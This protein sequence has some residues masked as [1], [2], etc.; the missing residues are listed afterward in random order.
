MDKFL[1][2]F[3]SFGW[4]KGI[5]FL[6]P[7]ALRLYL[8]PLFWVSGANRLGLF[9]SSDF[10]WYNPLT[11]INIES[12]QAASAHFSG[13]VFSDFAA[14]FIVISI[15]SFEVVAAILLILGLAV[16]WISL[17]L[18][19]IVGIIGY[20]TLSDATFIQITSQF[21]ASHGYTTIANNGLEVTIAYIIM[22]F[23]LFFM[24][25]GRFVSL[26]WFIYHSYVAKMVGK[27][28][29]DEDDL[30]DV[31][32]THTATDSTKDKEFKI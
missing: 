4:L 32:A 19:F 2:S 12:V 9:S 31:D 30:F 21:L 5:D 1:L 17:P 27:D 11:W 20:S 26:D 14:N 3:F 18:I 24:G 29:E 22:L 16:R 7:L 13:A 15:A 23:S 28:Q 6:A 25:A 8:A 10:V